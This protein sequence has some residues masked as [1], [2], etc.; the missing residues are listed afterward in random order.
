M[1]S[2]L[3][4]YELFTKEHQD[5]YDNFTRLLL[6]LSVGF[7]TLVIGLKSGVATTYPILLK[8]ALILHSISILTGIWLQYCLVVQPINDL[9]KAYELLTET[10]NDTG[11]KSHIF[12]RPPSKTQQFCFIIQIGSFM[13]AFCTLVIGVLVNA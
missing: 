13:A 1:N 9:K 7:I 4:A 10:K 12:E 11:A 8:T 2:Y 3:K 6:T 5:Q